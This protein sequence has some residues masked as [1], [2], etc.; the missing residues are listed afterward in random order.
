MKT[1][2][3]L[4]L[5]AI[6]LVAFAGIITLFAGD[7]GKPP[8]R[9]TKEQIGV[10]EP[11]P[12]QPRMIVILIDM[13]KS[14]MYFDE[15]K[16]F[17]LRTAA[18]VGRHDV[19]FVIIIGPWAT[20]KKDIRVQPDLDLLARL[21]ALPKN[22][23][24]VPEL[25]EYRL[26]YIKQIEALQFENLEHTDIYGAVSYASKILQDDELGREKLPDYLLR[27]WGHGKTGRM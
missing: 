21:R 6:G 25:R 18:G 13:T 14:Y 3:I 17:M 24:Y 5:A 20:E 15:A 11:T 12:H 22:A 7:I 10:L 27:L 4:I 8:K 26:N 23:M 16:Q 19:M 2:T 1:K 9:K